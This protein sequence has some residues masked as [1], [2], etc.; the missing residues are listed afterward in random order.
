MYPQQIHEEILKARKSHQC[1]HCYRSIGRGQ[2]YRRSVIHYDGIYTLKFHLDCDALWNRYYKDA[3]LRA[4]IFDDGY[5]PIYDDWRDSGEF[6]RLCDTYR[7]Y[8]PHAVTRLEFT[9]G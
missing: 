3:D 5:P 4:H 8:F 6:D 2:Q 9:Y 1:F 7:G